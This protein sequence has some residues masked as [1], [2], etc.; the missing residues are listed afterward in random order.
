[1]K[2]WGYFQVFHLE[3][4]ET[5]S[6]MSGYLF[7]FSN[8]FRTLR[9]GVKIKKI[10]RKIWFRRHIFEHYRAIFEHYSRFPKKKGA[11][12]LFLEEFRIRIIRLFRRIL[13]EGQVGVFKTRVWKTRVFFSVWVE[14]NAAPIFLWV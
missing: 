12:W 13:P 9:S 3:N 4:S 6:K 14:P 5:L 1:M 2:F 10:M 8:F 7:F 11:F